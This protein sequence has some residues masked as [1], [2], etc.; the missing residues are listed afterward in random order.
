MTVLIHERFLV[1]VLGIFRDAD[2]RVLLLNHDRYRRRFPWGLPGGWHR[3]GETLQETIIR[4]MREETDL[5]VE[6]ESF[7]QIV[8]RFPTPRIEFIV[9]GALREGT[10]RLDDEISGYRFV[11][12]TEDCSMI[13]PRHR[14]VLEM[15]FR[16]EGPA[17][18]SA[19]TDLAPTDRVR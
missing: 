6:V 17:L 5:A 19:L 15:Y 9:V 11:A 16:N 4:E 13:V 18:E 12:A 7:H 8:T 3:H 10:I 1:G 14:R 2:G